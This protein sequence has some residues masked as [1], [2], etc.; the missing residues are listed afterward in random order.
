MVL[1]LK[2]RWSNR[3][4]LSQLDDFVQDII[5][6]ITTSDWPE[7]ATVNEGTSDQKFTVDNPGNI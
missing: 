4:L 6:R 7:N 3:R 2:K 5:F 1:T